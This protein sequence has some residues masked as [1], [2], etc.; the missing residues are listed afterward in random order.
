MAP[1]KVAA[2][3]GSLTR[4]GRTPIGASTRASSQMVRLAAAIAAPRRWSAGTTVTTRSAG[5]SQCAT[6]APAVREVLAR[7]E[8]LSI[9]GRQPE[10]QGCLGSVHDLVDVTACGGAG[11]WRARSRAAR[12]DRRPAGGTP[13]LR[14][15]RRTGHCLHHRGAAHASARSAVRTVRGP[16][17][18]QRGRLLGI[19]ARDRRATRPPTRPAWPGRRPAPESTRRRSSQPCSATC[20]RR[21]PMN[22]TATARPKATIP[23]PRTPS[24][25]WKMPSGPKRPARPSGRPRAPSCWPP[26]TLSPTIVAPAWPRPHISSPSFTSPSCSSP[27]RR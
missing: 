13:Y 9:Q 26:S 24:P 14:T 15:G 21:G 18:G 23:S 2:V 25:A 7:I 12:R 17:P 19:G 3:P 11:R 5:G 10:S 20:E 22:G 16:Y 1:A 6:A 4:S 8:S 27:G